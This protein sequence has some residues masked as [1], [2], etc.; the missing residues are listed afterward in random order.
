M[1]PTIALIPSEGDIL[2]VPSIHMVVFLCILP[3]IFRGYNRG[4][5]L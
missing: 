4:A 3:R 5:H 2:K 1:S